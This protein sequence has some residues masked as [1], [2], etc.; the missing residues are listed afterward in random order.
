MREFFRGWRRKIGVGTLVMACVFA[1]GWMRSLMIRDIIIYSDPRFQV[2]LQACPGILTV[3]IFDHLRLRPMP[4]NFFWN[5][6][7]L[8]ATNKA[9][10][11]DLKEPTWNWFIGGVSLEY[12]F[13]SERSVWFKIR[14]SSIVVPA[15]AVS[16]YLLLSK[17]RVTAPKKISD[18]ASAQGT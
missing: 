9:M 10:L 11:P 13:G 7:L 17:P 3:V 4:N 16:A 2:S 6:D 14:Y 12:L 15:A 1:A 18:P 8:D 5:S